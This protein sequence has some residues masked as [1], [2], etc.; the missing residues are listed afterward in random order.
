SRRF[1]AQHGKQEVAEL[2]TLLQGEKAR[3]ESSRTMAAAAGGEE[4]SRPAGAQEVLKAERAENERRFRGMDRDPR[5]DDLVGLC[6]SGGG[7]RSATFNLGITTALAKRGYLKQIDYLSTVSGGGYI[8]SWLTAWIKREANKHPNA[9]E[10]GCEAV[11]NVLTEQPVKAGERY[12]EPDSVRF[13][14]KYSNYLAPR[15]GLLSTDLWALLAV[16]LRNVMLN[17]ALLIA[18]G[19]FVLGLPLL[20]LRYGWHLAGRDLQGNL[21]SATLALLVIAMSAI[22]YSFASFSRNVQPRWKLAQSIVKRPGPWVVV[23]LFSAAACMSYVLAPGLLAKLYALYV[24]V[25]AAGGQRQEMGWFV[26]HAPAWISALNVFQWLATLPARFANPEMA[27]WIMKG[28]FWYAVIWLLGNL[29]AR[30]LEIVSQWNGFWKNISKLKWKAFAKLV[31][32][33]LTGSG[34][35]PQA[36]A[37][38]SFVPLLAALLSGALGGLL[39]YGFGRLLTYLSSAA[40]WPFPANSRLDAQLY[41][42]VVIWIMLGLPLLLWTVALVSVLHVGLLGRSFPDAKREWLSRLCAML[43]LTAAAW[44]VLTGLAFYGAVVFKFLFLSSWAGTT[45]GRLVKWLVA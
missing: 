16:Y 30:L 20:T 13:L 36:I 24:H 12:L 32:K 15:T 21:I 3:Q 34:S 1:D 38:S 8:G 9:P 6:F 40:L 26:M 39:L 23:P 31:W 37:P 5:E 35:G 7:I 33:A 27:A 18:A 2:G 22:A 28:A 14:R 4:R 10:G 41:A 43:A 45:W 19:A 44:L 11:E 29:A 42:Q 17:L 25:P